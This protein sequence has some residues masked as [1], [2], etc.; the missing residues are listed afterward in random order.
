MS[1]RGN[2]SLRARRAA[3]HARRQRQQRLYIGLGAAALIMVAI[4]AVVIR[5]ANAPQLEDVIVPEALEIP[6]GADGAAWGPA[7]APVLFEEFSDF[8]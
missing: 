2:Q 8:Q 5:Q 1:S 3:Q 4:L 7:D 6:P